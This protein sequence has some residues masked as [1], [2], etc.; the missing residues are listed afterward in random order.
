MIYEKV[1][2]NKLVSVLNSSPKDN[3]KVDFAN[4]FKKTRNENWPDKGIVQDWKASLTRSRS[5]SV[6]LDKSR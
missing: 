5:R 2:S 3:V 1:F 6:H 4:G